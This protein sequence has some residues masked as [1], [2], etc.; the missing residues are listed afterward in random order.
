MDDHLLIERP[1][2][3]VVLV[4]LNRPDSLNALDMALTADLIAALDELADDD[5]CH[6]VVITGA[7]ERAFSAG[8]D[9]AEMSGFDSDTMLSAFVT[10]DPLMWRV[11]DH[12][13]P[14]VAALNGLTHGVGALIAAAADIRVGCSRSEFRVTATKYGG[15]NATWTLPAIVGVA[16]AKEFLLTG[17]PVPPDEA[18]EVGLLNHVVDDD[19]VVDEALEIA[20]AIAANP[21][22]GPQWVKKLVNANI[23]QSYEAG[24]RAEHFAMSTALRPKGGADVFDSFNSRRDA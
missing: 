20:S 15:A 3:H 11:A 19:R 12:P 5:T 17:R 24:Y 6:A 10:R 7:G 18:L 16:K 23:G 4:T 14:M 2:D 1:R 21:P 8:F 13:K 9:I 22:E